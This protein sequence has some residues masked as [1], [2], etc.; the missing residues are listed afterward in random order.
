M[1]GKGVSQW[2][3]RAR[4]RRVK[5]ASIRRKLVSE[6]VE[7]QSKDCHAACGSLSLTSEWYEKVNARRSASDTDVNAA[8][9][10]R[11]VRAGPRRRPNTKHTRLQKMGRHPALEM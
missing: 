1:D 7:I 5:N 6:Q 4:G 8:A 3:E 11:G 2:A 9:E 10:R